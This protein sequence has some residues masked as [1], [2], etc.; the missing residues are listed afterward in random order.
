MVAGAVAVVAAIGWLSTG[1]S[2][3]AVV[4]GLAGALLTAGLLAVAAEPRLTLG[5]IELVAMLLVFGATA[6]VGAVGTAEAATLTYLP[7]AAALVVALAIVAR[8][9]PRRVLVVNTVVGVVVLLAIVQPE[10]TSAA[11]LTRIAVP[12]VLLATVA[13]L[14]ATSAWAL[15]RLGRAHRR[16]AREAES[17]ARLLDAVRTLPDTD[18]ETA[19]RVVVATLVDAGA[20]ACGVVRW[21]RSRPIPVHLHAIPEVVAHELT[22]SLLTG[23][24]TDGAHVVDT[25]S[26]GPVVA[27]GVRVEGRTEAVVFAVPRHDEVADAD[28]ERVA[29]LAGHL[30]GALDASRRVRQQAQLLDRLR[31]L[32]K[33]RT[34]FVGRVSVDLREPVAGVQAA[35]TQLARQGEQLA[36]ADRAAVLD[37]LRTDSGRLRETLDALFD[38]ARLQAEHAAA[39]VR[40]F[41]A[42]EVLAPFGPPA[43]R[44]TGRVLLDP[45]LARRGAELL[46]RAGGEVVEEPAQQDGSWRVLVRLPIGPAPGRQL[47]VVS[48]EQLLL[49]AGV[50]VAAAPGRVLLHL[51][52]A[53][54]PA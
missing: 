11:G 27:A 33:L 22:P 12:A 25:P 13:L 29:V 35:A 6:V 36:D 1:G 40:P 4:V 54:G 53:E 31:R 3:L 42:A 44:T 46:V 32:E 21:E 49:H 2:D 47:T 20:R 48:A 51:E 26:L 16:A 19:A 17:R 5:R 8:G 9:L 24:A 52:V 34:T 30:G 50:R 28:R 18:P 38:L 37:R 41:A 43:D 23:T 14:G 10:P 39:E 15:E 7:L 45:V